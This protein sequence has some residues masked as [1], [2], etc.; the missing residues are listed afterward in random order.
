M[1]ENVLTRIEMTHHMM[2]QVTL[3]IICIGTLMVLSS[4]DKIHHGMCVTALDIKTIIQ[5]V[6]WVFT[7][8]LSCC[9]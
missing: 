4:F 8:S 5:D 2:L 3:I 7:D 6:G 1:N 9:R